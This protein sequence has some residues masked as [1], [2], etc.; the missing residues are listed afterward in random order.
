MSVPYEAMHEAVSVT[1]VRG[2]GRQ[3]MQRLPSKMVGKAGDTCPESPVQ[4][5]T[6]AIFRSRLRLI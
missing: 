1:A 5:G 2:A 6:S 4:Q 3:E